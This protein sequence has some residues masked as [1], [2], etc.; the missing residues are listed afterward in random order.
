MSDKVLISK[1]KG[2][3]AN[4]A[5]MLLTPDSNP[6]DAGQL[7]VASVAA[8]RAICFV[9]SGGLMHVSACACTPTRELTAGE[10]KAKVDQLE[11]TVAHL[12]CELAS[13]NNR[14]NVLLDRDAYL[15][16]LTA[17]KD[18]I[19]TA[20]IQGEPITVDE[21][22]DEIEGKWRSLAPMGSDA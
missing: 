13:R 20:E 18:I 22:R 10:W 12:K 21:L 14:D 3:G 6:N 11:K 15:R 8:G 19:R 17:V 16:Q 7:M 5:A 1:C 2:C 9:D 4:V